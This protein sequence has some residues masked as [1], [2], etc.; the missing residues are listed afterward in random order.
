MKYRLQYINICTYRN[1]ESMSSLNKLSN[2]Y[3]QSIISKYKQHKSHLSF[4]VFNIL[5]SL[6]LCQFKIL[7]SSKQ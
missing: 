4:L 6:A 3:V 5:K 7:F 2:T 1:I